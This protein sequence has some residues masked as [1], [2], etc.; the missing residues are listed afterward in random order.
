[1]SSD[2]RR[3]VCSDSLKASDKQNQTAAEKDLKVLRE[4]FKHA[5]VSLDGGSLTF[6]LHT[7]ACG[8]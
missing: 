6:V 5:P 2:Q 8:L 1:M 4:P 7:I 3:E